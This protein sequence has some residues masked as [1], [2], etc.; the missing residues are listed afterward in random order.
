MLKRDGFDV[1]LATDGLEAIEVYQQQKPDLVLL[2]VMMPNL[3]GYQTAPKLK[4]LAGDLYLPIIFITALEDQDSLTRCLD[5]G[6]DDFLSKPF[7]RVILQAKIK[8]HSRIRDL[9]KKTLEQNKQLDFYRLKTEREHR[10]VEHIFN[11]AFE[12]NY[13]APHLLTYHLSPASMF[14]GDIMSVSLGPTGNLYV[15][16][17]DFTGHG[18]AAAIGTLPVS[19]AFY[20]MVQKGLSVADIATEI[21]DILLKLL[22]DDMFCAAS[23]IELNNS[24]KSIAIW[25]G[26]TPDM[27]LI[28]DK[29]N[30]FR[31]LE[32][33]HMALG[34]LEQDE[35][36]SASMN[37]SVTADERLMVFTDG[38]VE[39]TDQRGQMFGYERLTELINQPNYQAIP[40]II[41][42]LTEFSGGAE[43]DDDISILSL[44]CDA[45]NSDIAPSEFSYSKLAHA[46]SLT[47]TP[48]D[49]KQSDPVLEI[50]D[51]ISLIKGAEDHRST[52]YLLLSEAYNN[53]LEHGLLKLPSSIKDDEDGFIEYYMQR[54]QRLVDLTDGSIEIKVNYVPDET[55][56]H[57]TIKDSGAGFDVNAK[58]SSMDNENEHGRGFLL[59]QELATDVQYN[60]I[61]NQITI[62]YQLSL[63]S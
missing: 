22:P 12:G 8:A 44:R 32:S 33:Q 58:V 62:I 23:I 53:A 31:T 7:D 14:N 48:E 16:M 5:V 1:V 47:L 15:M 28:D 37:Y 10:I 20:A 41:E 2:D 4:A 9:S 63:P 49:I 60:E 38:L 40:N 6:G 30:Q 61:G 19:R 54:E 39:I 57:F 45:V 21:N 24:G 36:D 18:L 34:I 17:G 51:M 26:G 11:R 56:L 29:T 52:L 59:L 46:F 42:K 3:D 35:F 13:H 43:Q 25:S 55:S 27:Y 50:I